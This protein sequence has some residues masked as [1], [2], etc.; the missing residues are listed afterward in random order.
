[1]VNVP[2]DS[3]IKCDEAECHCRFWW[4]T[5]EPGEKDREAVSAYLT[6]I[7]EKQ[8]KKKKRESAA[9]QSYSTSIHFSQAERGGCGGV[10]FWLNWI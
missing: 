3:E 2:F 10:I 1:M 6:F 8:K 4:G 7:N 5:R 9:F